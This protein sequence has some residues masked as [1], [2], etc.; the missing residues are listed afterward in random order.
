MAVAVIV[1]AQSSECK[2]L[3]SFY[4]WSTLSPTIVTVILLPLLRYIRVLLCFFFFFW[5]R[6]ILMRTQISNK[7]QQ[8]RHRST[9]WGNRCCACVDDTH[10]SIETDICT[11]GRLVGRSV[12][13]LGGHTGCSIVCANLYR[14][15]EIYLAHNDIAA[16]IALL[17]FEWPSA[18]SLWTNSVCI[19]NIVHTHRHTYRRTCGQTRIVVGICYWRI[20]GSHD[21]VAGDLMPLS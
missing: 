14:L 7:Q 21:F 2:V 19:R 8:H 20:Y 15:L 10:I 12:S 9:R 11:A 13:R 16:A 1:S 17:L 18:V 3:P 6:P 4:W 5:N